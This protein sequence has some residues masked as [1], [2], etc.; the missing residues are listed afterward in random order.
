MKF[1]I[2]LVSVS[3]DP[4]N[5]SSPATAHSKSFKNERN[6]SEFEMEIGKINGTLLIRFLILFFSKTLWIFQIPHK[7]FYLLLFKHCEFE[8]IA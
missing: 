7:Y 2:S 1:Y 6:K 8:L 3:I 5:V 4:D